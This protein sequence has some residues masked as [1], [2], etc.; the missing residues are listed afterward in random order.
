MED[1]AG[2]VQDGEREPQQTRFEREEEVS[3]EEREKEP[4]ERG[5]R[6]RFEVLAPP[7]SPGP[8][9]C[10]EE[11]LRAEAVHLGRGSDVV[12]WSGFPICLSSQGRGVGGVG[13]DSPGIPLAPGSDFLALNWNRNSIPSWAPAQGFPAAPP[14]YVVCDAWEPCHR[15]RFYAQRGHP[16]RRMPGVSL[17]KASSTDHSLTGSSQ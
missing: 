4:M 7:G 15:L 8:G 11:A 10:Q 6:G 3:V 14:P 16:L 1:E 17:E 12:A 9:D 5:G 2:E 13:E